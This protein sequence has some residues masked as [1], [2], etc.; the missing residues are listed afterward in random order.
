MRTYEE[1]LAH[2]PVDEARVEALAK[3]MRQQVRTYRLREIRAAQDITQDDL[4]KQ[5]KVSQNRISQLEHGDVDRS[6][7]DTL[8]RYVEAL[9]G[10]LSIEATFGDT[11][12][13]ISN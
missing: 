5:L 2:R 6:Q 10:T 11:S 12:Y 8:R 13:V 3:K 9:G 4:A 7:I 1:Q